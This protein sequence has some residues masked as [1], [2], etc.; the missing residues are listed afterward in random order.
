MWKCE[1]TAAALLDIVERVCKGL[2]ENRKSWQEM[3]DRRCQ[4]EQ[5]RLENKA[6][7]DYHDE[8]VRTLGHQHLTKMNLEKYYYLEPND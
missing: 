3:A 6:Q 8:L 5:W 4:S 7:K 1:L 2:I